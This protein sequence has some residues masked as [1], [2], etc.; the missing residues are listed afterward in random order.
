MQDDFTT[1]DPA[2]PV[3]PF[4]S[5]ATCA[6]LVTYPDKPAPAGSRIVPEVAETIPVP[7]DGG[8]TYTFAIRKGFRF[9]PPSNEPVT[10]ATFKST[11]ERLANPRAKSVYDYLL[12]GIVGYRAFAAGR[13]RGLAGVV[14]RGR[15][16]TIRLSK[17]DGGFLAT[18]AAGGSCAVP[19]DTP[20]DLEANDYVPSAGPYYISSHTPRQQLVMRRNPNYHGNR[21]HHFDQ[22]VFVIGVAGTRALDEIESGKADYA[23]DLPRDAQPRLE[24]RYGPGSKA[25]EAGHQQYFISTADG[26]FFLHMNASRPLFSHPRL[27]RAVNYAIDRPALVAQ[28]R[29]F[30]EGGPFNTGAATDDYLPPSVDGAQDFHVYPVNGP[31]LVRAKR[32]AGRVQATAIMYTPNVPPW[33]QETQLVKRNLKP[34]G[35]DVEVKEFPL[36]DYFRRVGLPNEPFDLALSGW[37]FFSS[38]PEQTLQIFSSSI[39]GVT[40]PHF[41]D[42]VFDRALEAAA[43]L[44]GTKRD[45]AVSR[46]ELKLERDE[47][48]AAA[49]ATAASRDFFSARIG[50]QVYQPVYGIDLAALCLRSNSR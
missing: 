10:A 12:S 25:A 39:P 43:R 23:L 18:L 13:A 34:L 45:R 11:L 15:T 8:R 50:C 7:T 9:S 42:P 32:L 1:L 40:L 44:S 36:S 48:P 21:P 37:A 46:I 38:D 16:L 4:I 14:A 27:R 47:A 30:S 20:P 33:R 29:R 49:V 3:L 5:Y 28:G 31:D 17:P 24:S 2:D 35:I 41:D 22:I 6:N 26:M 19:R